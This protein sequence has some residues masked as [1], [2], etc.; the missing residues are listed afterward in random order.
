[1]TYQSTLFSGYLG[2]AEMQRIVSD[3]ALI[4]G[5]VQFEAALAKGQAQLG[6]ISQK[7]ADELTAALSQVKIEPKDLVEGTLQ[8][9]IPIIPLLSI[10]K[11]N[12]SSE[13][14]KYLHFGATS[15][16]ALDT[17]QVL[18]LKKSVEVL[19]QRITRLIG[20]LSVLKEKVGQTPCMA[21]TRGQQALPITFDVKIGAWLHPSNPAAAPAGRADTT[22]I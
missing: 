13:A 14:Q 9:G 15:Q 22:A 20:H 8:H 19:V 1:M 5:I 17:A 21:H 3:E 4:E 10:I 12:L 11:E 16:D 18:L 7:V 6:I 2:D